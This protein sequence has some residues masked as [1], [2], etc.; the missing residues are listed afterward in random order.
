MEN[1]ELLPRL[2]T[3]SFH[4]DDIDLSAVLRCITGPDGT[5]VPY[6]EGV[7]IARCQMNVHLQTIYPFIANGNHAKVALA[8]EGKICETSYEEWQRVV[9]LESIQ[10]LEAVQGVVSVGQK[11]DV[12]TE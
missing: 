1:T 7:L 10:L 11:S 3:V 6:L 5:R 12:F 4:G 8:K 2:Y 9:V